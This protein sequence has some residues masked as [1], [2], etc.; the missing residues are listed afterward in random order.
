MT[1]ANLHAAHLTTD[2]SVPATTSGSNPRSTTV[3]DS[4]VNVGVPVSIR[5]HDADE[6]DAQVCA[7]MYEMFCSQAS[8]PF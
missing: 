8:Q 6:D 2:D 1:Q 3:Q 4:A 5:V 7:R